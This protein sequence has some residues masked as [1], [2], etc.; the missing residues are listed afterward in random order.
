MS[1]STKC[2]MCPGMKPWWKKYCSRKCAHRAAARAYQLRMEAANLCVGCGGKKRHYSALCD[3]CAVKQRVSRRERTGFQ[4][5]REGESR[6]RRPLVL[7]A[8]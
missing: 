7:E 6:G 5:W 2:P 3:D 1:G 8:M 4:P